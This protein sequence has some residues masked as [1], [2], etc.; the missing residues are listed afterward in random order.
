[1]TEEKKKKPTEVSRREFLKD[2]GL[3]VGG[4]AIGSTV[5][6]AACSGDGATETVTSTKTVTSTAPGS[7]VTTT[8]GAG[9]TAT[10]TTTETVSTTGFVC[11]YDGQ[12]F[13]SLSLL[14]SHLDSAHG[15]ETAAGPEGGITWLTVNGKTHALLLKNYWSLAFV[16]REKL[17]LPAVKIGCSRGECGTCTVIMDGRPVYS[18][19]VLAIEAAGKEI[20]IVEG[21]SDGIDL[22]LVQQKFY[23]GHASQCGYCTS[24]FLMS[25]KAL[26][27]RKPN[28][29]RSEVEEAL[30]GHICICG[31]IKHYVD[32]VA[33]V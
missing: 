12:E 29:S 30:S 25:A 10:E 7:T 28:P 8:V 22:S 2:A 21:L 20:L 4:T 24:G 15:G 18:C 1:M 27:D 32:A 26:L 9:A 16:L 3:L 31:E 14:E 33:G 23:D 13:S 19:L 17:G 5:L 6:L 11:P